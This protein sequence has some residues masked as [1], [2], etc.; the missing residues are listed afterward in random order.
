MTLTFSQL[1]LLL[2]IS[3]LVAILT[4][5]LHMPYTVGL[6]LAGMALYLF[7]V[8]LTLH[9][10]KDLI[11]YVFLPP[12]VFEAALYI[13]WP[14]LKRDLPVVGALATVGLVAAAAVTA[15]GMHYAVH[16]AWSSAAVFGVLIAATDPV[17]V[18][19]TFKEAGVKGRLRL[20]V[21]AESLL[22]DGTAAVL[23]VVALGIG[24]GTGVGVLQVGASLLLTM[25]GGLLCGAATALVLMFLAGRTSDH[26]IEIT[27][28]TLA[29]Y[30]SFFVAERFHF[31]G[32]LAALAAG[33]VVGNSSRL[34]SISRAGHLAVKSFWDY[35]AFVVNSLIF[36]LIGTG[37]TQQ[38]FGALWWPALVA[39][40]LVTLGRAVAIYPICAFFSR[41]GLKVD[42]RHQHVLFWGGLRGALALALA[43]GLPPELPLRHEIVTVSFAVVAFSIFAQG[44]TMTPLLRKLEQLRATDREPNQI[45]QQ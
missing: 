2:F 27:C 8:R 6:V 36:L 32:V 13:R 26:L 28:T 39:I 16:W 34:G 41:S 20:L 12:L 33:L 40:L 31:S 24:A 18:V 43:L 37:E 44:L 4:R 14:E 21:E 42:P 29:A 7:A 35:V 38:N 17:S 23:F 30:G 3:T 9:L 5:R 45:P 11:F 15:I 10:S 22:N 19:A 1:G 25:G